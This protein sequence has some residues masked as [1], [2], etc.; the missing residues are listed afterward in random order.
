MY[1]DKNLVA[2]ELIKYD[3]KMLEITRR[4]RPLIAAVFSGVERS[5]LRVAFDC[6]TFHVLVW[7]FVV[8]GD[9]RSQQQVEGSR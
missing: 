3:T 1:S 2:R 8:V 4:V 7:V 6:L 9:L 5:D